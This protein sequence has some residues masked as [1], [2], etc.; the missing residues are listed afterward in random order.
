MNCRKCGNLLDENEFVCRI[1]GENNSFG[2]NNTNYV[3][4]PVMQQQIPVNQQRYSN[5]PLMY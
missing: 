5:Q 3:N 2:L 1:C 4:Q